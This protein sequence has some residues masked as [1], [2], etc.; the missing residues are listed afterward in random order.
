MEAT[1]WYTDLLE[2]IDSTIKQR[3]RSIEQYVDKQRNIKKV[4]KLTDRHI[5]AT[6]LDV[7]TRAGAFITMSQDS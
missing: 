7:V 2:Y 1:I 4:D 3:D 5:Q 6:D